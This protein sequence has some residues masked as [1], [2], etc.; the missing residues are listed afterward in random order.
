V[1]VRTSKEGKERQDRVWMLESRNLLEL[2]K[3]MVA[4]WSV[5]CYIVCRYW[6]IHCYEGI[7]K[8]C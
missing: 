6:N 8:F 1:A 4:R 3:L 2:R 5:D 7:L